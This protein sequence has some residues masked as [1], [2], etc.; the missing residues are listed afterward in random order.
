MTGLIN[1]NLIFLTW[2]C[3]ERKYS[4]MYCRSRAYCLVEGGVFDPK[5]PP[6]LYKA[7]DAGLKATPRANA[8]PKGMFKK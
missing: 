2:G 1:Q 6:V 4:I 3:K 7:D 5:C 8:M